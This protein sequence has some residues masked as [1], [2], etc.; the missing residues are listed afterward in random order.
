MSRRARSAVTREATPSLPPPCAVPHLCRNHGGKRRI[1]EVHARHGRVNERPAIEARGAARPA[2]AVSARQY[3][4]LVVQALAARA[5]EVRCIRVGWLSDCARV[6]P[7]GAARVARLRTDSRRGCCCSGHPH[8]SV[9]SEPTMALSRI[10]QTF[11]SR[12]WRPPFCLAAA[13]TSVACGS[14]ECAR[15]AAPLS[16]TYTHTWVT[17]QP[18]V[19][20]ATSLLHHTAPPQ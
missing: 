12:H 18:Q 15:L 10:F 3:Q 2:D 11:E 1:C 17:R 13:R 14:C 6:H 9:A 7:S 20:H 19:L 5:V 4:R 8:R 16:N